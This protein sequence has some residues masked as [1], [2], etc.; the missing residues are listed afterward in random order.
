MSE[1]GT[2][3]WQPLQIH[4]YLSLLAFIGIL[5]L[6]IVVV[7]LGTRW[8]FWPLAHVILTGIV[9]VLAFVSAGFAVKGSEGHLLTAHQII[10]A[11]FFLIFLLEYLLGMYISI[12][13]SSKRRKPPPRDKA[14]WWL[15]RALAVASFAMCFHGFIIAEWSIWFYITSVFL[16]FLWIL[17]YGLL[18]IF[19]TARHKSDDLD[20]V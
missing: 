11:I 1:T 9:A 20:I 14:H 12:R 6:S 2:T 4:G 15:G 19:C 17:L 18:V 16:L 7:V 8:D 5:P 13:W 10:G 3:S